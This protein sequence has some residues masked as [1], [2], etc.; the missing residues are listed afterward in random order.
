[1]RGPTTLEEAL[2]TLT[3]HGDD[4]PKIT[5]SVE[6]E[7]R[8]FNVMTNQST[9]FVY[10]VNV[11]THFSK[12]SEKGAT[13]AEVLYSDHS[14]SKILIKG[15]YA[16]IVQDA[17]F[18]L[19]ND[20][21]QKVTMEKNMPTGFESSGLLMKLLNHRV[22]EEDSVEPRLPCATWAALNLTWSIK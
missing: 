2:K 5:L 15:L 18:A 21:E 12:R 4:L 3:I 13:A 9:D 10:R 11:H 6:K 17:I 20:L 19:S 16:K 1:M 7:L 8:G 22:E 14:G